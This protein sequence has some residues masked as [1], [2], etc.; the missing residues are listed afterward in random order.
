[1][2]VADLLTLMSTFDNEADFSAGG[3]DE[4][5]GIAALNAAL[6]YVQNVCAAMPRVLS[7]RGANPIATAANVEYA[8]FPSSLLRLD[9]L[10]MLDTT[11]LLPIY[12]LG[13]IQEVGGHS[14]SIP[15]VGYTNIATGTGRPSSYYA[16][17][18]SI[19]F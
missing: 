9:R 4:S 10:W 14:P 5:R 12:P 19:Y 2:T 15:L 13:Q 1:M 16:D 3:T 17:S 18:E 7:A 8:A 11:S 6:Q